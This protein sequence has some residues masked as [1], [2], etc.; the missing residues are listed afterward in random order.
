MHSYIPWPARGLF[1][2][3]LLKPVPPRVRLPNCPSGGFGCC[4]TFS[5]K[6]AKSGPRSDDGI[7]GVSAKAS[8]WLLL[9]RVAAGIALSTAFTFGIFWLRFGEVNSFTAL[10]AACAA[11]FQG[12]LVVGLRHAD[13]AE[14]AGTPNEQGFLFKL[15]AFWLVAVFFGPVIGWFTAEAAKGSPEYSILLH[16]STLILTTVLPIITSI[17]NYRYVRASSAYITLPLLLVVS[18]LPSLVGAGS[19]VELWKHFSE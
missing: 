15:G 12:L 4:V 10:I 19:A 11:V 2:P 9:P 18:L 5:V 16:A 14:A 1:V 7:F 17:P 8:L 3:R 13:R 6:M